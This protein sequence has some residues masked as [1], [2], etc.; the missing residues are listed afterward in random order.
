[1]SVNGMIKH[2]VFAVMFSVVTMSS[3]MANDNALSELFQKF[4]DLGRE[5]NELRGE[6]EVLR[7]ELTDLK[8]SQRKA[9]LSL[10]ERF[11]KQSSTI[12]SLKTSMPASPVV[13]VKKPAPVVPVKKPMP[14]KPVVAVK[15]VAPVVAATKP[16][17]KATPPASQNSKVEYNNAYATLKKN[18]DHGIQ[19]FSNFLKKYPTDPLAENAHYWIGEAKYA[20]KDYRGAIDSFVVVLNKYKSGRKAPD[21][22]V[23]LGYSFYQVKDWDLAKRTFNDVLSFFPN[24]NAA[25]LAKKRLAQMKTEGH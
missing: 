7:K 12:Q 25:A 18:P 13:A 3:V 14:I 23:K 5:V 2:S 11:E 24:T 20:K 21:A 19:S 1:M 8:A 15:P 6:N 17:P 22:A 4:E 16:A 10:D 9:F